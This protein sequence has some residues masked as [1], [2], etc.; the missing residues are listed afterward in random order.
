MLG[1]RFDCVSVV[2]WAALGQP[3]TVPLTTP[4]TLRATRQQKEAF[5]DLVEQVLKTPTCQLN[6]ELAKAAL[7]DAVEKGRFNSE[8]ADEIFQM[9]IEKSI[10]AHFGA[11]GAMTTKSIRGSGVIESFANKETQAFKEG[12][13]LT[14]QRP[15]RRGLLSKIIGK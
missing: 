6:L 1:I 7:F 8:R 11:V 14:D 4:T 13:G 9:A 5:D 3:T 10:W 2:G 12:L 15:A